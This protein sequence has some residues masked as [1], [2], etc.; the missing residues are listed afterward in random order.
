MPPFVRQAAQGPMN[1]LTPTSSYIGY[2]N[3]T[4]LAHNA[5]LLFLEAN[6]TDSVNSITDDQTNTWAQV[7]TQAAGQSGHIWMATNLAANT[8]KITTVINAADQ[9]VQPLLVEVA[10]VATT[11]AST[12]V[13][14]ST[15]ATSIGGTTISTTALTNSIGDLLFQ[16]AYDTA[17]TG[18]VTFTAG[19][20][21]TLLSA[22]K[23]T[24]VVCQYKVATGANETP[25]LTRGAGTRDF[26]TLAI[27]LKADTQ[28]ST[29]QPA[30]FV[31]FIQH[32]YAKPG[33]GPAFALQFPCQGDCIYADLWQGDSALSVS[34]VVDSVNS[35][36]PTAIKVANVT[37]GQIEAWSAGHC[38]TGTDLTLTVTY[39]AAISLNASGMMIFKDIVGTSTTAIG[40][41]SSMT[42]NQ[43]SAVSP[44]NLSTFTYTPAAQ[45][46]VIMSGLIINSHCIAGLNGGSGWNSNLFTSPDFDGGDQDLDDCDGSGNWCNG[47]NTSASTFTWGTF[48]SGIGGVGTWGS[49]LVEILSAP[50]VF[51]PNGGYYLQED[52]LSKFTLEDGS[53]FYLIESWSTSAA[54]SIPPFRIGDFNGIGTPGRFFKSLTT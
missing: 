45:N 46:S 32:H 50:T 3:H 43:T 16:F 35:S 10:G 6:S 22:Q 31:R 51:P 38:S 47:S 54:I 4:S 49:T 14:S 1:S 36:W 53:G 15:S 20:G 7:A 30:P 18:G 5:A 19:S 9:F 42:G 25:S 29:S 52:G 27:A 44:F 23:L 34:T 39:S 40:N 8:Q 28:G 41:S 17:Q 37:N 48:N 33:N 21:W 12:V 2:L 26:N 11:V 13:V 24:G